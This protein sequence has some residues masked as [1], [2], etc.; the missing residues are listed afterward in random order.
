M[1]RPKLLSVIP[2]DFYCVLLYE[3]PL[4]SDFDNLFSNVHSLDEYLCQVSLKF[5]HYAIATREI[6]V[7]NGRTT[8]RVTSPHNVSRRLLLATEA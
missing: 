3:Y 5:L 6:D 4:I 7:I 8:G 2:F 1:L